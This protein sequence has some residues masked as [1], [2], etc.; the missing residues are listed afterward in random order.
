MAL[1]AKKEKKEKAH[2]APKAVRVPGEKTDQLASLK[3]IGAAVVDAFSGSF[4]LKEQTAFAKRLAFLIDAGVP[5]VEALHMLRDQTRVRAHA[6]VLTS[7]VDDTASGQALAKSFGKFPKFFSQFAIQIIKVGES[8]GTLS[9]S[10]VFL[11][12]E[13]RKRQALKSKVIGALVYPAVLVCATAGI[14]VFLMVYLFPKIMPI[15]NSLHATLPLT[16]RIVIAVSTFLQQWGLLVGV[17]IVVFCIVISIALARS[18]KLR[19]MRDDFVLHLP[20]LGSMFRSFQVANICRTLGLL[21]KSGMRLSDA[22][23]V[24]AETTGNLVYKKRLLQLGEAVVRGERISTHLADERTYF[25]D[26]LTHLVAVG[27]RSG[28]L[29]ETLVYLSEM[30]DAEVDDFTKNLSTLIEP[31]LMVV[32]GIVVGFIAIS[33]ISPIYGITQNLHA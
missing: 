31:V 32:M 9:Q 27:E 24:T 19:Y 29:S 23:P 11:A 22:L 16:T 33:I 20:L 1:F 13:L 3:K 7:I 14:T 17:G 12:D 26:M 5:I 4:S 21:L 30:Y 18:E 2:K 8:S 6:A 28:T 15:F 25:P 10:L